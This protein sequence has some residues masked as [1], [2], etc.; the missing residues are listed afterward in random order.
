MKAT[1]VVEN[2]KSPSL[3]RH[4]KSTVTIENGADF[5][6]RICSE[7]LFDKS[8]HEQIKECRIE[9]DAA[10]DVRQAKSAKGRSSTSPV[11]ANLR[12]DDL[13]LQCTCHEFRHTG[14]RSFWLGTRTLG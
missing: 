6:I 11:G 8:L 14:A 9:R 7:K 1:L 10:C 2:D 12:I 3:F 4:G 13:F 5:R